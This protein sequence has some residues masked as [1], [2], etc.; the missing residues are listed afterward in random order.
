MIKKFI[1]VLITCACGFGGYWAWQNS[2]DVKAYLD[3]FSN[4]SSIL[5]FELPTSSEEFVQKHQKELLKDQNH[6]LGQ[7]GVKFLPFLL[8]DVKYTNDS[9]N[10]EESKLIWNLE[11]GEMVLDT[12]SFETT[13]GFEDCINAKATD[14]D[15]RIMHALHDHGG[16]LAKEALCKDV[17][18]DYDLVNYRLDILRKKQLVVVR[19]DSVRIHLQS[20]L[21]KV[22]PRTKISH[23][24]VIKAVEAKNQIQP[25]YSK[26]QVR[27]I[28]KAAF[29]QDF[30]IRKEELVFVP[31]FQ[32]EVLNP[33]GSILKTYWNALNGK[34]IDLSKP[35]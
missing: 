7:V 29:G 32:I 22:Q 17:G 21:F 1:F 23:H 28:A 33:D 30:A 10:T 4:E 31:I 18:L 35:L 19:G 3:D 2:H 25:V 20:P 34:R 16:S 8:F 26:D 14:D 5:T 6:A 13:H 27:K 24:F 11:N 12:E 15:F 9:K